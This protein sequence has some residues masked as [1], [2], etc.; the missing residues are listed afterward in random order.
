MLP[1]IKNGPT[2]SIG[3]PLMSLWGISLKF[4]I[5]H[6]HCHSSTH[7]TYWDGGRCGGDKWHFDNVVGPHMSHTKKMDYVVSPLL[8]P[9]AFA[10]SWSLLDP[11]SHL[12]NCI[13]HMIIYRH[14]LEL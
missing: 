2:P 4:A 12:R 11:K 14:L 10:K 5:W 8:E 3:G 13:S 6:A 7:V 9:E 1:D